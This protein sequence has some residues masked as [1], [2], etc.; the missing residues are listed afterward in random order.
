MFNLFSVEVN[1]YKCYNSILKSKKI[2]EEFLLSNSNFS[3][4]EILDKKIDDTWNILT[5]IETELND[6]TKFVA[7]DKELALINR[8]K[9]S[10]TSISADHLLLIDDE[11]QDLQ[12]VNFKGTKALEEYNF[13][14][15]KNI[16][17]IHM[18]INKR[19]FHRGMYEYD[20]KYWV[21]AIPARLQ[22]LELAEGGDTISVE[23]MFDKS[24]LKRLKNGE[25]EKETASEM[26]IIP[27]IIGKI[28]LDSISQWLLYLYE[29]DVITDNIGL[30]LQRFCK[31]G[32]VSDLESYLEKMCEEFGSYFTRFK[33]KPGDWLK[34]YLLLNANITNNLIV[35][36][37]DT[38]GSMDDITDP[39]FPEEAP[40]VMA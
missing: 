8:F 15:G 34:I 26:H 30:D 17:F 23:F 18:D 39:G 32:L 33:D 4:K 22:I 9:L 27:R 19:I 10:L 24:Q 31:D 14:V 7:A 2:V 38:D 35:V 25:E 37:D 1:S 36:T 6:S 11:K 5:N 20:T 16:Y 13:A 12:C 40:L 3:E 28:D 21:E 29:C